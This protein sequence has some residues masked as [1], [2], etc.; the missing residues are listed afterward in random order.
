MRHESELLGMQLFIGSLQLYISLLARNIIDKSNGH[1]E[2]IKRKSNKGY[3]TAK[4][5]REKDIIGIRRKKK[6]N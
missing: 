4:E 6:Q 3:A 5:P 2:R 1:E